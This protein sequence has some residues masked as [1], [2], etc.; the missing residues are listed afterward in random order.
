[1]TDI[2]TRI[3]AVVKRRDDLRSQ[4]ERVLGRLEESEK[5]LEA[6]RDECRAKNVDPDTLEE[7]IKKLEQA[8]ATSLAD[9]E[10]QIS[11]AE[12]AI[13]PYIQP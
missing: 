6:L 4:T 9:Y 5:N 1:M 13:K 10:S 2:K 12:Q 8:L 7:T 11:E 3:E